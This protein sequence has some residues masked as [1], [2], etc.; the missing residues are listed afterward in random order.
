[1]AYNR[2]KVIIY[3]AT[4]IILALVILSFLPTRTE[5]HISSSVSLE[6]IPGYGI[7][8][9]ALSEDRVEISNLIINIDSIEAQ[10]PNGEWVSIASNPQQWDIWRE[11]T[12]TFT[13]NGET[14]GFSKLRLNIASTG[15]TVTLSSGEEVQLG[16]S[17]LPLEVDL[18]NVYA[19]E[20]T[21]DLLK[22]SLS[23]G[24]MSNNILPNLQV[25][26]STTKLTAEII[27]Q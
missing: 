11:P 23:Q 10:I 9:V 17:S 20:N 15:S 5:T 16:V 8:I 24:T 2:N 27:A 7:Q 13:I 14:T 18:P 19:G 26:I 12:K 3:G 6:Q 4:G 1:M 21:G 25:M 22:L